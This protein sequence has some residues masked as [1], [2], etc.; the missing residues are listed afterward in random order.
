MP[1]SP[2]GT[3]VSWDDSSAA[4]QE[5]HA[6]ALTI[7]SRRRYHLSRESAEDVAQVAVTTLFQLTRTLRPESP[8]KL[9][10]VITHRK[11]LDRRRWELHQGRRVSGGVGD[12]EAIPDPTALPGG[13]EREEIDRDFLDN[14]LAHFHHCKPHCALVGE[15][16]IRGESMT[17]LAHSQGLRPNTVIKRLE[18]CRRC[19][20]RAF[21]ENGALRDGHR[22]GRSGGSA[23]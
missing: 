11:A 19:V 22:D 23:R 1:E 4:W 2:F 15:M 21:T 8:G 12:V 16:W 5:R 9:L 6:L 18:R 20:R 14:L 7:A 3:D 17:Q 10:Y 13:Q